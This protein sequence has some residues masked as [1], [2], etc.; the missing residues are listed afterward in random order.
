MAQGKRSFAAKP[1]GKTG[2]GKSA[3]MKRVKNAPTKRKKARASTMTSAI[4]RNIE[5]LIIQRASATGSDFNVVKKGAQT[6]VKARR[7]DLVKTVA[8]RAVRKASGKYDPELAELKEEIQVIKGEQPNDD[9]SYD[10][11]DLMR[12]M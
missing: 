11:G 4:N 6:V 12:L 7:K 1:V 10:E 8:N 9:D 5:A 2:A 3:L